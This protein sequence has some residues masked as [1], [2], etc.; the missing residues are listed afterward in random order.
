MSDY[1]AK[2]IDDVE[3]LYGGFRRV[4]A[5]LGVRSFGMQIIDLPPDFDGHPEHDH[6]GTGQEEVYL[7]LRGSGELEFEDHR[8]PLDPETVVRVGPATRR[9]LYAGPAGLRVL[10]LGGVPGEAYRPPRFTEL[11]AS[12]LREELPDAALR[13]LL[14][15]PE[16]PVAVRPG[17]QHVV[18]L[19]DFLGVAKK[20]FGEIEGME[21][22]LDQFLTH[23][24]GRLLR[25]PAG[26][27][28][29][30]SQADFRDSVHDP[31]VPPRS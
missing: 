24:G 30:F 4:R 16:C 28:F 29:A 27:A 6:L 1:T 11:G 8:I 26:I 18:L 14:S 19:S 25:E 15:D 21:E 7:A 17:G 2:R 9:K 20:R 23:M 10:A 13:E 22:R 5:A 3:A 31:T 12:D